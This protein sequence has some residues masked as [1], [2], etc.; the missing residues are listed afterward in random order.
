M[1]VPRPAPT[2][3][4]RVKELEQTVRRIKLTPS[5]SQ[6][7]AA[8]PV[9]AKSSVWFD[10]SDGNAPSYFD[11]QTWVPVR[12][13]T[14]AVA[15]QAADA[16]QATADEALAEAGS[17]GIAPTSSP[18]PTV[19]AGIGMFIAKWTPLTNPD[20]VRYQVHVSTTLGFTATVD[21]PATL[22]GTTTGSQFTVRAL[23]GPEPEPGDPDPRT[24][25][26]D[27]T[28]YVRV[29][30]VDDDGAAPQSLQALASVFRVTG[31]DLAVDSV[32]A[33]NIVAGTLTGELFSASVIVA[34]TFKTAVTGQRVE[35]GIAG[36]RGYRSDGSLM[37]YIPTEDGQEMLL[38]GEF[39]ARG[40][41]V[42]GGASFQ[43]LE[44]EI[45][46]DAAMT[47]M[48]G[49][50]APSASPQFLVTWD[51]VQPSTAGLTAAEKTDST[52]GGLGGPF[53]LIPSEVSYIE[54]K[55]VNSYWVI[56][57]VRPGGTRSWFFNPDGTPKD[58]FGT[59]KY[60]ND[61]R[62]WEIWSVSEM[63]TSSVPARNGVYTMFR[64]LQ[65]AG[66]DYWVSSPFGFNR[67]SR[68]NGVAPPV[69][70]NNGEDM[71]I[72]EVV[73]GLLRIRYHRPDGSG[74]AM[75]ASFTN[76]ESAAGYTT[77]VPLACVSYSS[78]GF[79]IGAARYL[80]AE[81]SN[82]TNNRLVYTSGTN[83]NSIF[84]GGS[85]NSWVSATKEA[86]SF[87]S[88]TT[89][90][91]CIAWDG[92]Q[93]WTYSA[94]GFLY[95]HTAE[96]W[97]PSVASSTYWGKLTFYD[98]DASGG[99]HETKGGTAKSYFAKRRSKNL[100]T[101]PA[102]PDNGGTNDPD[103]VRLYMGRGASEPANSSFH[104]QSETSVPVT[105]TTLATAT[106]TPP[107]TSNFPSTNPAKIRN[108]DDTAY[109][110]GAGNI[111][112]VTIK[113]GADD[114]AIEG[115]FWYGFLN[116][117]PAPIA[118]GSNVDVTTWTTEGSPSS[119]GI[120]YSA[121]IITVPRAGR[122]RITAQLTWPASNTTGSRVCQV[123]T[124]SSGGSVL[125]AGAVTGNA[126]NIVSPLA[127]KTVRLAAGA[128]FRVVANQGSGSSLS[129][130]AGTHWSFFQVEW[131]GP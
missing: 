94:D 118:T 18:D 104:L 100:F 131:V 55:P 56:H 64:F 79:D 12:D 85:G 116:S 26:Y 92:T 114:V 71:F 35:W 88:P 13:E 83:A 91:R 60:F 89:N 31:I 50:V 93:F 42:T 110:D 97:D 81:R 57:Q 63:T 80:T 48:R 106:A 1:T 36:I 58:L 24:L 7:E 101:P 11:G 14:I 77:G 21:D 49:I 10:S 84:P 52:S 40:L 5:V 113:R 122:Y 17:D 119:S 62:D 82:G 125:V 107:T 19:L 28:Y 117:S 120:T 45:T 20:P 129:L 59:G 16:A 109:I 105:F 108:D 99:T 87:E 32:T 34:G 61:V 96:K 29:I 90:R 67:Y 53:E 126:A 54:W 23:P 124:G 9:A 98:S 66:T 74:G 3:A 15:Q 2:V 95:K 30:A 39:I 130:I 44:N 47:L 22:V 43:S 8:P 112:G 33:A 75:P 127:S 27:T 6:A 72:A 37:V 70:G 68:Q 41:T 51:S 86:E 69:L 128:T 38:D 102:I 25:D 121:G 4:Q 76:Y 123:F 78:T 65:G 103:K 115:P 73:G 46:A 111:L